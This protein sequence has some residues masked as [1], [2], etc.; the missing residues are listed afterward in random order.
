VAMV[1]ALVGS[2][3]VTA[4]AVARRTREIGVRMAVGAEPF[5]VLRL[6][7]GES[8]ATT[9]SG[10]AVGWML[11]IGVGQVLAS[12]FVDLAAFDAWTFALAP[13]GSLLAAV[14][15]TWMPAR[16]AALVNQVIALRND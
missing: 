11:G 14:V 1:V 8:L 5:S 16:R 6:I 9:L 13:L 3:G 7:L 10:I 4:H 2:Y 12:L 15:A